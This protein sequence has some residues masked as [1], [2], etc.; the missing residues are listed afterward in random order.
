M[1][2]YLKPL[3]VIAI[4]AV[5]FL[6]GTPSSAVA[7]ATPKPAAKKE[8]QKLTPPSFPKVELQSVVDRLL[9]PVGVYHA[10]DK[11]GRLFIMEQHGTIRIWRDGKLQKKPFLD[12]GDRIIS[13]GERGLLGFVFHPNYKLN[14][15]IFVNYTSPDRGL[16]TIISEFRMSANP[17]EVDRESER[18]LLKIPQPYP[19]HKGGSLAFGADGFLYIGLGDGGGENDPQGH[20]QNLSSLLG[21]ILRID[22]DEGIPYTIPPNNPFVGKE[23][24]APELWAVGFRNPWRFSFDSVSGLLYAADVGQDN[25]EEINV[26]KKGLNYG[27]NV[28]EG[29]ICTPGVNPKCKKKGLTPPIYDYPHSEGKSVIGGYVYRGAALPELRGVYIYGDFISGQI[30]GL[31]YNGSSL[32]T[33]GLLFSTP[34][35]IS[36]FGLDEQRELYVVDYNGEVLKMVPA[37]Q[38]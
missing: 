36:A 3:M 34:R 38:G 1:K 21:K 7:E 12:I 11:S 35:N 26:I 9:Q 20:G 8:K 32:I 2:R 24:A 23:G 17:D 4:S 22:T 29:T 28:M 5:F 16:H 27:W 6:I 25:R 31:R 33:Q 14:R 19:N 37:H 10:N 30:W 18:I 13:G 15:R